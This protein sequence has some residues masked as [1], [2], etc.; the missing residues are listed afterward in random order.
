MK[1]ISPLNGVINTFSNTDGTDDAD[2]ATLTINAAGD[3][4]TLEAETVNKDVVVAANWSVTKTIIL[5]TTSS[6]S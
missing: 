1:E 2:K 6:V 5:T 4:M 3:T